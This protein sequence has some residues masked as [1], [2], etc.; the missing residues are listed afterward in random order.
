MKFYMASAMFTEGQKDRINKHA[1]LLRQM[2]HTVY[3]PHELQIPN[4]SNLN[5]KTWAR[6][7]FDADVKAID[8]CDE[9]FYFCEGMDGD[10]GAAWE[11]GYAYAKGKVIRVVELD[12][13]Q[14]HISLMVAQC[15]TTEIKKYQS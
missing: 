10:L 3:V 6:C 8:E 2:G 14:R 13:M 1:K 15:S 4:A 5:N 12:T 9:M 11:C 7:V